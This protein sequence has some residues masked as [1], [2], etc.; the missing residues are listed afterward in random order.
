MP[1][2]YSLFAPLSRCG[3]CENARG[4][5]VMRNFIARFVS[6]LKLK[7]RGRFLKKAAQKLA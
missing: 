1:V 2:A 6:V 7:V 5:A 3:G 4:M